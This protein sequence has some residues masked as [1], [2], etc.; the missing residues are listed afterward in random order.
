MILTKRK[1]EFE[2]NSSIRS[3]SA[4][5]TCNYIE[6]KGA[7]ATQMDALHPTVL[8]LDFLSY[9]PPMLL[10]CSEL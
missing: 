9:I 8:C 10:M 2:S 5:Q 3:T 1:V 6:T 7:I 4:R